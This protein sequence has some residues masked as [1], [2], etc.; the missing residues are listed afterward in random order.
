[1]KEKKKDREQNKKSIWAREK[2]RTVIIWAIRI[3]AV[4]LLSLASVMLFGRTVSIQENSMDPT[5]QAGDTVLINKAVYILGSPKRGDVIVYKSSDSQDAAF[6]VKRVIGLPGERI[7]IKEGLILINGV[8]YME[9]LELPNISD[10]GIAGEGVKLGANEYFV[11]GDNRNG[12]EDSRFADVGNISGNSIKGRI[13][14][15]HAPKDRRGR[16]K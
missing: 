1:M 10:P 5:I 8:T 4:L 9:N 12:S 16:V 15:I 11:L 3:A 6:H 13:W 7:Q 14:F 2:K